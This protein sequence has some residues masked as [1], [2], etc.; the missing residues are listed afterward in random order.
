MPSLVTR[1]EDLAPPTVTTVVA[2]P[3]RSDDTIVSVQLGEAV[4]VAQDRLGL[5][6]FDGQGWPTAIEPGSRRVDDRSSRMVCA[7]STGPLEVVVRDRHGV[8]ASAA[9]VTVSAS[10]RPPENRCRRRDMTFGAKPQLSVG[11]RRH[12]PRDG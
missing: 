3:F 4:A 6:R 11:F 10:E 8:T 12:G 1:H 2:A 7:P 5:P 9:I